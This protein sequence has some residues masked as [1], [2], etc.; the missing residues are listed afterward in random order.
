MNDR[1]MHTLGWWF[2]RAAPWGWPPGA[3]PDYGIEIANSIALV[4]GLPLFAIPFKLLRDWLPEYFQYWGW[5]HLLS[6]VLQAV[7]AVLIAHEL[8]LSRILALVAALFCVFQPAFLARLDVHLALSGHWVILAAVWLYVKATPPPRWA[9]PLLLATV[10]AI[11][12]YLLVMVFAT[13]G[14]ALLQRLW[15]RRLSLLSAGIETIASAGLIAAVLWACGIFMVGSVESYDFGR[16]RMNLLGPINPDFWSVVLPQ[17][18]T[19]IDEWEGANYLGIGIFALIGLGLLGPGLRHLGRLATPRYL[20]I[21]LVAG[22]MAVF[23]LS[24]RV[25]FGTIELFEI[26]LPE[27]LEKFLSTFRSTGRF[28]WPLGYLI[29][30][31]TLVIVS[32]RFAPRWAMILALLLVF[33]QIYDEQR[34][35]RGAHIGEDRTGPSFRTPLASPAWAA[36]APHYLRVRGLPA[37]NDVPGWR[38][39]TWFA[40]QHG[41][42]SAA[43]YLGRT[44]P[45]TERYWLEQGRAAMRSGE[46]DTGAIYSVTQDVAEILVPSLRPEDLLAHID[47]H[48]IFARNGKAHLAAAGITLEPYRGPRATAR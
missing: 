5:W 11:H 28:F 38:D 19:N 39:L 14:A 37:R 3:S 20:P 33:V 29:I 24:N 22:A 34:G 26:A 32:K 46:L 27:Q 48:I 35:W 31:G 7:F 47:G 41:L 4:D 2:F 6:F 10:S 43:V 8:R 21:V 30:F 16:W 9:W 45:V 42:A 1:A 25:A 13:W 40:M 15:L 23:A 17:V 44:D 12:G 36:L 18:E